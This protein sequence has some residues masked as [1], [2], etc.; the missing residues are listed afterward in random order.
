[1]KEIITRHDFGDVVH[2]LCQDMAIVRMISQLLTEN[3]DKAQEYAEKLARASARLAATH[4][5]L[6]KMYAVQIRMERT[7]GWQ[8]IAEG[9]QRV[10]PLKND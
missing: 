8:E 7:R 9:K 10:Y 2:D 1:M 3:P 5:G 4:K 6:D